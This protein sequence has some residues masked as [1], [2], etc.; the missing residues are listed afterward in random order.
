MTKYL[1]ALPSNVPLSSAKVEAARKS[2]AEHLGCAVDDVLALPPGVVVTAV[3]CA[4][5][6]VATP[7]VN[8][9]AVHATA[10]TG[11]KK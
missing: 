7:V 6:K 1:L 5:P 9:P 11:E 2:V 8:P 4:A 10:S 3:A